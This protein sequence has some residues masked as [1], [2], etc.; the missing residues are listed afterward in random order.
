MSREEVT[1]DAPDGAATLRPRP[2]ECV[3]AEKAGI[4][5]CSGLTSVISLGPAPDVVAT[6]DLLS[7]DSYEI[8]DLD[9]LSW[10]NWRA[11]FR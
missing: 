4:K 5:R 6:C 3:I 1:R 2:A 9:Q 8:V 7:A 11:P 10:R